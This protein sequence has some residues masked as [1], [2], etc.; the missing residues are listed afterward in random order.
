MAAP[1]VQ[2]TPTGPKKGHLRSVDVVRIITVVGVISI[3]SVSMTTS[4]NSV[5]AGAF[6]SF[7]HIN[8]DVFLLLSPFV[9]TYAYG[10]RPSYDI[11]HFWKRRYWFVLVP[12]VGWSAIYFGLHAH[13]TSFLQGLG[14]FGYELVSGTAE[15]H[16]YFLL[17]SMQLYAIYPLLLW[18]LKR[19]REHHVALLVI[20]FGAQTL[21][22]G[23]FMYARPSSGLLGYWANHPTTD[24]L[25]YQFYVIAGGV[26]ALH[27]DEL[28]AWVASRRRLI[29]ACTVMAFGL[30]AGNYFANR[31]LAHM[32][33]AQSSQVFQPIIGVEA[34]AAA[35]GLLCLGQW[36]TER[37]TQGSARSGRL[38]RVAGVG[39][40]ASF[41][42]YLAHPLILGFL[43]WAGTNTGILTAIKSQGVSLTLLFDAVILIPAVGLVAAVGTCIA[44]RTPL[45][46]VLTGRSSTT[47][48]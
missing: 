2:A 12:Y 45:S 42:I 33:V 30:G 34:I 41:G 39:S 19:L 38:L 10:R 25:T 1:S 47:T 3:H 6:I 27:L 8:R 29:A 11:G 31:E 20:S 14:T 36:V 15:Y 46:L 18:A 23:L 16:L 32:S 26:A 9:L 40:D 43:V 28:T 13:A 37:A 7:L 48:S 35:I 44:R 5:I 24:L 21:L 17:L 22:T 4:P